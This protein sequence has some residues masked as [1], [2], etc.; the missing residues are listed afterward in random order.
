MHAAELRRTCNASQAGLPVS[1]RSFV[2]SEYLTTEGHRGPQ[3][4]GRTLC[5]PLC[6]SVVKIIPHETNE[7]PDHSPAPRVLC[8]PTEPGARGCARPAS[9]GLRLG[10][11]PKP[12]GS[13]FQLDDH[14]LGLACQLSPTPITF[15]PLG[16]VARQTARCK[17]GI[18]FTYIGL[19]L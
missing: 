6:P 3:R 7:A 13:R 8:H 17:F 2:G 12:A 14:S 5:G 19:S 9:S 18:V 16:I 15:L 10:E 11:H 4:G 1:S